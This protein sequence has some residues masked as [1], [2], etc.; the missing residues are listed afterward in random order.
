[1]SSHTQ[2]THMQSYVPP[3]GRHALIGGKKFRVRWDERSRMSIEN[4]HN[5]KRK[6]SAEMKLK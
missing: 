1:M 2:N 3:S 5:R 4:S 6:L